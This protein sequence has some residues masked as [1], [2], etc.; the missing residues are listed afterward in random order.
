MGSGLDAVEIHGFRGIGEG[1]LE[2]LQDVNFLVGRNNSGKTTVVEAISRAAHHVVAAMGASADVL[3]RDRD[4]HWQSVRQDPTPYP[5]ELAQ[6]HPDAA[7]WNVTLSRGEAAYGLA[8]RAGASGPWS[9]SGPGSTSGPGIAQLEP[10]ALCTDDATSDPSWLPF[11]AGVT[12]F[13]P[14]DGADRAVERTLWPLLISTRTDKILI[15][16]LNH[17]YGT[18]IEQLQLLPD[19]RFMVLL[20]D[21][22]LPLDAHGEGLRAAARC[23]MVLLAMRDTLLLLEEPESHQHPG[24]L[25]RFAGAM[26]RIARTQNVQLVV[27]THSAEAVRVFASGSAVVGSSFALFHMQ[28]TDGLLQSR[29]WRRPTTATPSAIPPVPKL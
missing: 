22:S 1:K 20:P 14:A 7:R 4:E 23:L 17:I 21:K 16:A 19:G 24:S 13:R 26:C 8:Y 18:R 2:G 10:F 5:L 6:I 3:S 28:L 15:T 12:T 11:L 25:E 27:T 9:A 29:G